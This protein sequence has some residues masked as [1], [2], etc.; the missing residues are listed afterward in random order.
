MKSVPFVLL[1]AGILLFP[2]NQARG[3]FSIATAGVP[4]T[5]NFNALPHTGTSLPATGGIFAEGWA[6]LEGGTNANGFFQAGNG[7]SN[8]GDSY[9]FGENA[10]TE[11][12]FGVLQSG[13]LSSILGFKF[14]NNTGQTLSSL[15]IGYTGEIWRLSGSPDHLVFSYQAGDVVLNAPTGW[16]TVPGLKF[17][18]PATGSLQVDGNIAANRVVIAPVTITGMSILPGTTVT[19]R[20]V[21]ETASSSAAMAIDDFSLVVWPASTDYFRTRSSGDWNDLA[22][23]ETSADNLSWTPATTVVPND[24]AAGIT[25]QSGHTVTVSADL[26]ASLIRVQAGGKLHWTAGLFT[27]SD[28][29]GDDLLLEG[30]DSEWECG[31]SQP[32]VLEGGATVRIRSRARIR[33][34]GHNNLLLYHTAAFTYAAESVFEY[35]HATAANLGGTLFRAQEAG[36]VPVFSY[37][38]PAATVMSS[39]AGSTINGRVEVAA[40][41]TLNLGNVTGTL[42]I[43]NGILGEGS[44]GAGSTIFITGPAAVLG[45]SGTLHANISVQAGC[46]T[47]LVSDKMVAGN[48]GITVN[49]TLDLKGWQMRTQSG[50]ASLINTA[51]GTIQTANAAGLVAGTGSFKTGSFTFSFAAGS[52]IEYNAAADQVVSLLSGTPYQHLQLAGSGTKKAES[53]GNLVVQGSCTVGNGATLALTGEASENLYLNNNATLDVTAGAVFDNGG[54]SSITSSGGSPSLSLAGTFLTRDA[55][56]FVGSGSSLPSLIPVILPGAI[57]N[58]GRNGDQIVQAT[59]HYQ[60]LRFSGSGTKTPSS[61]LSLAGTLAITGTATLNGSDHTI[62]GLANHLVMTGSSRLVVGGTGTQ[63]AIGGLYSLAPGTTI[64]FSNSNPTTSTIRQGG[65]VIQYADVEISGSNVT[66]PLSGITLQAG[67]RLTVKGGGTLKLSSVNGLYG[68]SG[69]ALLS[70]H[71]PAINLQPGSTIEY[72]GA[73][74]VVTTGYP[75][76]RLTLAGSGEKTAAAPFAV[77]QSLTISGAASLKGAAPLYGAGATLAYADAA[78]GRT[79]LQGLEWP[80]E[81][82]PQNITLQLSGTGSPAVVLQE[83][84]RVDGALTLGAGAID[85]NGKDLTVNGNISGTG[86]ITGHPASSLSLEGGV[87]LLFFTQSAD[88]LS[89]TLRSLQIRAGTASLGNRLQITDVLDIAGGTLDLAGQSL[90]LRSGPTGAARVAER[91][92][93]LLRATNVTVERFVSGHYHRRW[94]LLTAPVGGT[95]VNAAWQEGRTWSGGAIDNLSPG[96]G[97]LITGPAQGTAANATAN[98]F[99][100]WPAITGSQASVRRY[101]GAASSSGASWQPLASTHTASFNNGEA[102]LLFVRGDRSVSGTGGGA[103]VLRAKGILKEEM[104]YTIP[105]PSGQS[106]ALLGNPYA[107]PLHFKKIYDDNRQEIRSYYWTWQTSLSSVGGYALVKPV[108]EGSSRYE[109][110]PSDGTPVEPVIHSGEGFFVVPAAAPL[111]GSLVIRQGH[112]A[113]ESPAVP[114]LR[115]QDGGPAKL[116]INLFTGEAGT[117]TL[118]DGSL[119]QFDNGSEA[120]ERSIGKAVNSGENLAAHKAGTDLQVWYQALPTADGE[121]DLRIWNTARRSYQLRVRSRGFNQPGMTVWLWDRWLDKKTAIS[122]GHALT[123][124]DFAVTNDPASA[125]PFRFRILYRL[126]VNTPLPLRFIHFKALQQNTGV[127]IEWQTAEEEGV[128]AFALERSVDGQDFRLLTTLP[129]GGGPGPSNYAYRDE[130]PAT[131]IFYRVAAL[132]H[133][134]AVQY[135]ATIKQEATVI[136]TQFFIFPNPVQDGQIQLHINKAP[137]GSYTI[138]LWSA[139]GKKIREQNRV[140]GGGSAVWVFNG[141]SSLAAGGYYLVVRPPG[142]RPEVLSFLVTN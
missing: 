81:G 127:L 54:E 63:P 128:R 122:L 59:P 44:L 53:G 26:Q 141:G 106:H 74:Q 129:A 100:F 32:P 46:V 134:S 56:G 28:K 22:V 20:W 78:A 120:R 24:R 97:T 42:T 84:R 27:L 125:D 31:N 103:T 131:V 98:G 10:A 87:S 123:T 133:N 12:A 99:D 38:S 96:Y 37:N 104:A 1:C 132:Y 19:L 108:A 72:N 13:S 66:A 113:A 115:E 109:V 43:R 35:S 112:K 137:R 49:G 16:T 126:A 69:A 73:A 130:D 40:G 52:T 30:A 83:N 64:I 62:G 33:L 116:Y 17:T 55:Q 67:A 58:F 7:S 45:G 77:E 18:T 111:T 85:L 95:S 117:D 15:T 61:A 51:T 9:S 5:Q 21:D 140:Y 89:N 86:T 110:I 114:V 88:G 107:S 57:V 2:L 76:S 79:Y 142:G 11:R 14:T 90:V 91:K 68:P 47:T 82:A 41:R 138:G 139:E 8:T 3:Q 25:I 60:E 65:P 136:S 105:L 75:Y 29:P 124:Y 119:L 6:F 101:Q 121:T 71:A 70:T 23:W 4:V 34:S 92:G 36:A 50:T 102:Y 80:E 118:L 135:S 39:V 48:R 94:R 93:V